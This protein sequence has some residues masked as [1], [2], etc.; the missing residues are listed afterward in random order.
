[1]LIYHMYGNKA[2]SGLFFFVN[3]KP[4]KMWIIY[5]YGELKLCDIMDIPNVG[6]IVACPA[7]GIGRDQPGRQEYLQQDSREGRGRGGSI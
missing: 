1:M 7:P 6:L 2:T 5:S 4:P 3:K